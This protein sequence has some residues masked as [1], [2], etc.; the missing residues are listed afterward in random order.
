MTEEQIKEAT[1]MKAKGYSAMSIARC[2]TGVHY[3]EITEY[4]GDTWSKHQPHGG[5]SPGFYKWLME[6]CIYTWRPN[7]PNPPDAPWSRI[8]K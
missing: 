1:M 6:E 8:V 2:L 5:F 7:N 3:K 4:F